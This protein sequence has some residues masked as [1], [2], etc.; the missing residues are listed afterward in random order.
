[1]YN[2]IFPCVFEPKSKVSVSNGSVY[3]L[4]STMRTGKRGDILKFKS[5]EK[6]HATLLPKKRFPI[7]IDHIHFLITRGGWKVSKVYEYYNY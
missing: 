7:F 2:E 4:L 6:T 1:M 3:Q 5:S